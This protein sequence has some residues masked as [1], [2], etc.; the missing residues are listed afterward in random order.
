MNSCYICSYQKKILKKTINGLINDK[1]KH[2]LK[3]DKANLV[4][5][6]GKCHFCYY[7]SNII[8]F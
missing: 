7:E 8:N 3:D 4:V 6:C 5:L 2:L 1:K